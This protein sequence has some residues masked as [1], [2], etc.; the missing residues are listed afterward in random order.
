MEDVLRGLAL[1]R[2]RIQLTVCILLSTLNLVI[3]IQRQRLK[4]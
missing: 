1:R 4:N 2:E 3:D